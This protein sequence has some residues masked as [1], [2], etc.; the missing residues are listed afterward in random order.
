M[1]VLSGKSREVR[2]TRHWQKGKW[3]HGE[4]VAKTQIERV[5][6]GG[7]CAK[8]YH[9]GWLLLSLFFFLSVHLALWRKPWSSFSAAF[10]LQVKEERVMGASFSLQSWF[11]EELERKSQSLAL[12]LTDPVSFLLFFLFMRLLESMRQYWKILSPREKRFNDNADIN[13]KITF[14]L[15]GSR[16]F[17]YIILSQKS[18]S[19]QQGNKYF[20][21]SAI[22]EKLSHSEV[23][24]FMQ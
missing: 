8:L 17:T 13:S 23:T 9:Q 21:Y 22:T 4:H 12:C 24:W 19:P 7:Y 14:S 5:W 3:D 20:Y 16:H 6:G 11:D 18:H 15:R 1:P 2:L 10:S